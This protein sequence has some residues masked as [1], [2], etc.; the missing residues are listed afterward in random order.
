MP[1]D[2]NRDTR[3]GDAP[4]R[5]AVAITPSDGSDLAKYAKSLF[6]GGA[7]DIV[8]VPIDS[9]D[10]STITL[11]SHPVGYCPIGFRKILS[12]G[13]TANNIIGIY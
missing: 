8:G 6:V 1:Y 5:M 9:P 7:G 11:K 10:E 2:Q 3:T 4:G 13:T 12:T